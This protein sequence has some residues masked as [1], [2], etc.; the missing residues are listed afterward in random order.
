MGDFDDVKS[1]GS[2]TAP[3]LVPIPE[4]SELVM[5]ERYRLRLTLA[6]PYDAKTPG[7]IHDMVM[8]GAGLN[9]ALASQHALLHNIVRIDAV[10]VSTP[11]TDSRIFAWD[12]F[13]VDITFTK[14][15]AGSPVILIA[16][17][18]IAVILFALGMLFVVTNRQVF[19]DVRGTIGG[20]LPALARSLVAP[21]LAVALALYVFRRG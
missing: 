2:S 5:G 6:G 4:S 12:T 16:G 17:I 15:G 21:A 7:K 8:S 20:D 14:V 13:V 10:D 9:N 19:R 1:G 18:L 11:N 3:A